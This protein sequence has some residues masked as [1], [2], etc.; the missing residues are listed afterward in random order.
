VDSAEWADVR[1]A[2]GGTSPDEIPLAGSGEERA[3]EDG[4]PA[5]VLEVRARALAHAEQILD[6]MR[7]VMAVARAWV[8]GERT[9]TVGPEEWFAQQE[10]RGDTPG[11][12]KL[13]PLRWRHWV[14]RMA[15]RR[16][17]DIVREACDM[18]ENDIEL[19]F[20]EE[21]GLTV[22]ANPPSCFQYG[23]R[24]VK[25][26]GWYESALV[27]EYFD[28]F[29]EANPGM[30]LKDFVSRI[31]A[32]IVRQAPRDSERISPFGQRGVPRPR[33]LGITP[34]SRFAYRIPAGNH[35]PSMVYSPR[36]AHEPSR[37]FFVSCVLFPFVL[38]ASAYL[39]KHTYSRGG[40]SSTDIPV[41]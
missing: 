27:I 32:C 36:S 29:V 4:P 31:N 15:E 10:G 35:E 12:S 7:Y 6:D 28:D 25:E 2:S 34:R 5:A 11:K 23:D 22:R 13:K 41:E 18:A 24:I 14:G 38:V 30:T 21:P 19:E 40:T 39:F 26:L 16:G 20:A 8:K 1:S 37:V 3:G 9:P 33:S 17:S